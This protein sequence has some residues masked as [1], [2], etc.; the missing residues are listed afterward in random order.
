MEYLLGIF[1]VTVTTCGSMFIIWL[2]DRFE[3]EPIWLLTSVSYTH[4][5]LP[6]IYSV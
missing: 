5:T 2:L 3:K 6:T 1:A 4:L